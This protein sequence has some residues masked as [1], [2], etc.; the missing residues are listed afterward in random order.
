MA[1]KTLHAEWYIVGTNWR[2]ALTRYGLLEHVENAPRNENRCRELEN[3]GVAEQK[4][5]T[6]AKEK[7]YDGI[8]F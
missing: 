2:L 7:G 1:S 8:R 6:W 5:R 3:R 4:A